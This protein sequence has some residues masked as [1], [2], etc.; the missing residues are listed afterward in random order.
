MSDENRLEVERIQH[1]LRVLQSERD[2][3]RRKNC[4][5]RSEIESIRHELIL[6]KAEGMYYKRL[7][8]AEHGL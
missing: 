7:A 6:S 8:E 5:L 1:R 3:L 2:E 4:L